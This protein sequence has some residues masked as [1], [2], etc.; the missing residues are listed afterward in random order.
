MLLRFKFLGLLL[1]LTVAMLAQRA[2]SVTEVITFIKSQIKA[3]GDDRATA[4]YLRKIK[5]TQRLDD[6]TIEDL[7]GQGAGPKRSR[8]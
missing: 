6:R 8:L 5:L 1:L 3:N 7:Q 2:M 4:D